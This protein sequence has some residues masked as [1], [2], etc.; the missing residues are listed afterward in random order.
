MAA[1]TNIK[2]RD[3]L[4]AFAA[5]DATAPRDVALVGDPRIDPVK[6]HVQGVARY[7]DGFVLTH[8]NVD[9]RDGCL[10]IVDDVAGVAR[11]VALA[12][13]SI[14]GLRLS[15]PG[16]C[17]RIGD[18]LVV[19]FESVPANR[20]VSRIAFFDLSGPGGPVLLARPA[21]IERRERKAGCVGIAN[22]TLG[23]GSAAAEAWFVGVFDNGRVDIYR[24]DGGPFPETG[25]VHQFSTAIADG[26]EG[27]SLVAEE[28]NRLFA[29][30]FRRD[31]RRRNKSELYAV[32]LDTQKLE[33]LESREFRTEALR[34]VH[35]R[36]GTGVDVRSRDDLTVL[37][38]GRNFLLLPFAELEGDTGE[39]REPATINGMPSPQTETPAARHETENGLIRRHCHINVF[40]R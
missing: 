39:G 24:S 1:N 20:N 16:G 35:F 18:Y 32:H 9:G 21:P 25:F 4:E 15:H 10:L 38:T 31:S 8:S 26:Y 14:N 13:G 28:S 29:I 23:E 22:L 3:V 11:T 7:G 34:S 2:L 5:I 6:S 40:Q 30:G 33:L 36:W 19:A 37:S 12:Q 17:Q 27:F